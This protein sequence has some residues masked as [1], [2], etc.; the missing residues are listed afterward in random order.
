MK[1]NIDLTKLTKRRLNVNQY[2][3]LLKI[4]YQSK[5]VIIPFEEQRAD[6]FY[7]SDNGFL[8][9][10]GANVTLKEKAVHLIEDSYGDRDYEGLA[11]KIKEL[12]PKGAKAGKWPWR[13]T[14]KDLSDRL[15]NLD[16][17]YGLDDFPDETILKTTE[18]YVNRFNER[19]MDAGMQISKYFIYK[20]G[21]SGLMDLLQMGD[22][23]MKSSSAP[24][25]VKL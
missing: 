20:D 13:S 22:D 24:T 6:Y 2:L 12:F 23:D 15:K 3:L 1:I 4:Y 8:V 7:L 10:S 11:E 16:K 14:T 5:S 21:S 17:T 9:I 25:M 19:D 18:R